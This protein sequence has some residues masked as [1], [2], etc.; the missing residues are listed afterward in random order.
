MFYSVNENWT[1]EL[2]K[3]YLT[4]LDELDAFLTQ[5]KLDIDSKYSEYSANNGWKTIPLVF[6]T[7]K[8][9]NTLSQ[10]PMTKELLLKIPELIGAEFSILKPNTMIKPHIG[11]SKQVMRTHL[12]LKVPLGDLGL[13]CGDKTSHWET[14]TTF[15][16]N[17]GE[18]HSAWNNSPKERWVLMIDTPIPNSPY[19]AQAISKYKIENLDDKQLL[20]I[21]SKETW[22][23]WLNKGV[24]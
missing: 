16:F 9:N 1:K 19:S 8:N 4:I 18:L 11:Y 23:K 17:D 22:T 6:F 13:K 15:S 3:N 12:G 20:A 21:A 24:F 5:N 2:H 7:I 10:F 14:G